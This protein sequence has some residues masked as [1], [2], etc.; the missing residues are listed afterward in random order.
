MVLLVRLSPYSFYFRFG[1]PL[2]I[3][4]VFFKIVI[5]SVLIHFFHGKDD[6]FG[7]YDRPYWLRWLTSCSNKGAQ[8]VELVYFVYV[9]PDVHLLN[10]GLVFKLTLIL[11]QRALLIV[12]HWWLI[13]AY[14]C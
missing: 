5:M 6:R 1:T 7:I 8:L 9:L 2:H 14:V 13:Y 11:K 12:D 3:E 4:W 10:V